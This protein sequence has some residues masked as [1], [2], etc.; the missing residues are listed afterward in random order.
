MFLYVIGGYIERYLPV[1]RIVISAD[2]FLGIGLCQDVAV[3]GRVFKRVGDYASGF[4][5]RN[6]QVSVH[7]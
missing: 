4:A 7:G 6:I 2:P 5:R 1:L 3:L